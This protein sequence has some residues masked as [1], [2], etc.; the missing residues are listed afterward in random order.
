MRVP[1]AAVHVSYLLKLLMVT[2]SCHESWSIRFGATT[3][4]WDTTAPSAL[5]A[6][7]CIQTTPSTREKEATVVLEREAEAKHPMA[8]NGRPQLKVDSALCWNLGTHSKFV[9]GGCRMSARGN[10]PS[11]VS[12]RVEPSFDM[13]CFECLWFNLEPQDWINMMICKIMWVASKTPGQDDM[14]KMDIKLKKVHGVQVAE[15]RGSFFARFFAEARGSGRYVIIF[16]ISSILWIS[17]SY[18]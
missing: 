18:I 3:R 15:A 6:R 1:C 10:E 17:H 13:M 7:F 9:R 11:K 2:F 16:F 4:H 14:Q 12:S 5:R 8:S